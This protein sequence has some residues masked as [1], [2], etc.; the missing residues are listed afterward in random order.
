MTLFGPKVLPL[1]SYKKIFNANL[2]DMQ[3]LDRTI[4]FEKEYLDTH[5]QPLMVENV[6]AAVLDC[7]PTEALDLKVLL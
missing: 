2:K 4:V 7:L 3:S 6:R 1:T 5:A